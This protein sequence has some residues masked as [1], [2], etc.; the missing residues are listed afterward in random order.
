MPAYPW[1]LDER[2]VMRPF[3]ERDAD[4]MLALIGENRAHLDEWLR[5]SSRVRSRDDALGRIR[6]FREKLAAGDGFHCG[7]WAD[8][9]LAG[10]LVCHC[11]DRESRNAEIGYWLGRAFTGR[12]LAT[13][14][15]R[16]ALAH[17]FEDEGLHR[18][19]MLCG[20]GN[21]RSRA[22]PERLG[23]TAEGVRRDSHWISWRFVDH[24][25]YG[26]LDSEW[27]AG[28]GR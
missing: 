19:E 21:R 4:A 6:L 5:W 14:A 10:G 3:E 28:A 1:A 12:G 20:V 27:R 18:I 24:V 15:S 7:I 8:G 2:T 23:F 16:L 26:M 9:A 11:I 22:V 17:L 13:R 25:I